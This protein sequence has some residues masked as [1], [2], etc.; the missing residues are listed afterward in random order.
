MFAIHWKQGRVAHSRMLGR[1]AFASEDQLR[2]W[3][4]SQ[5]IT[6]TVRLFQGNRIVMEEAI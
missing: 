6:G 2:R 3:A 5:G 4:I 1:R